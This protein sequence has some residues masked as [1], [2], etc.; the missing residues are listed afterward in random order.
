MLKKTACIHQ[1]DFVPY[2]GFFQRLLMADVF[3][4]LDDVQFI[5]RGWQHRDYI[6]G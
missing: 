5:R 4:I 1:P 3:V 6:K 2:L